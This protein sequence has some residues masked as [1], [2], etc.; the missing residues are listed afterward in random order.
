MPFVVYK[1]QLKD[2]DG[3]DA[4]VKDYVARI[5]AHQMDKR[6]SPRPTAESAVE[7]CVR[8]VIQGPNRPDVFIP[9]YV[10]EDDTQ[11]GPE[12]E[13]TSSS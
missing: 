2:P 11:H 4:A 5:N 6:G 13:A 8:R 12:P 9:D 3:F 1:S 10:I 7:A